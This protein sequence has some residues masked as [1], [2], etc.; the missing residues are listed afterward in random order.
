VYLP[1]TLLGM[2]ATQ[3]MITPAAPSSQRPGGVGRAQ[4]ERGDDVG[5]ADEH[6]SVTAMSQRVPALAST[7]V[8]QRLAHRLEAGGERRGIQITRWRA[9]RERRSR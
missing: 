5:D 8:G 6:A 4:S 2:N 3:N 1:T 9:R 7:E